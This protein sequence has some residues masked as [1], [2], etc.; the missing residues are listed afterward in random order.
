MYNFI[1][2]GCVLLTEKSAKFMSVWC[3]AALIWPSS[4][5]G[6]QSICDAEKVY[7]RQVFKV[8]LGKYRKL[9]IRMELV[10]T[11]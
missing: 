10:W 8:T 5:V 7:A 3:L 6:L 9:K 1:K 11:V 2:I 4:G